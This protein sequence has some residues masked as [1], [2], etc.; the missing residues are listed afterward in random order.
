L[1]L[2]LVIAQALVSVPAPPRQAPEPPLDT[3]RLSIVIAETVSQTDPQPLCARGCNSLFL[4]GIGMRP[5]SP[6]H[7]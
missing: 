4:G 5:W 1:I 3:S 7:Q 6:V 2:G